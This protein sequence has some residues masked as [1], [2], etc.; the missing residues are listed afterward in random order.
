V[1]DRGKVR[2]RDKKPSKK[3]RADYGHTPPFDEEHI[4]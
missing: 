4:P 1:I 2:Q 3:L